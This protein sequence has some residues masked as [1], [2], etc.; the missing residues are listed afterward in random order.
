MSNHIIDKEIAR[1]SS[2]LT[3]KVDAVPARLEQI[4]SEK[5]MKADD[6]VDPVLAGF[7]QGEVITI[8]SLADPP[9]GRHA[10]QPG[11]I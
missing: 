10:R 3:V 1:A 7:D 5:L 11:R 2:Y 4:P 6:M 8:P 9:T